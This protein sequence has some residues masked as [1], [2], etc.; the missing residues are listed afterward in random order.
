MGAGLKGDRW[1][2]NCQCSGL[3]EITVKGS[4]AWS[5]K[6]PDDRLDVK[7]GGK[8]ELR[9]IP[10]WLILLSP[11]LE[12]QHLSILQHMVQELP[13]PWYPPVEILFLPSVLSYH[14]ILLVSAPHFSYILKIACKRS[15]HLQTTYYAPESIN[16]F[17]ILSF[18]QPYEL[19][20]ITILCFT[21]EET[22]LGKI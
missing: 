5:Q 12:S 10:R 13:A 22:E 9:K 19:G 4:G 20:A 14:F 15:W 18:Q 3:H 16:L 8:E 2:G 17:I 1:Q 7:N 6:G 21:D 11:H